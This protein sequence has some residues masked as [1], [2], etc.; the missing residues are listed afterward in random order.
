M[1]EIYSVNASV[2][3]CVTIKQQ[4][5][6]RICLHVCF[7]SAPFI[8]PLFFRSCSPLLFV[9]FITYGPL[10]KN[11]SLSILIPL[12]SSS[13]IFILP[14]VHLAIILSH[15]PGTQETTE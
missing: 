10:S 4:N 2:T 14:D 11:L 12:I 6:F 1:F 5:R 7:L 15:Y 3:V 8:T 9:I 13:N